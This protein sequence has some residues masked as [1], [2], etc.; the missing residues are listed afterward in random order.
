MYKRILVPT[1]GSPI[2]LAATD[3]ALYLARACG[4]EIVALS[5]ACPEALL[6]GVE[7]GLVSAAGRQ[8]EALLE[9]ADL[10]VA[11][12][13]GRARSQGV[14]CTTDTAYSLTPAEAIVDAAR[15]HQCDLI[16]MGSHG[17]R[18]LSDRL[19]G[20]VTQH[21]LRYSAVP[22]MVLRPPL[23]DAVDNARF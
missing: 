11:D 15:A 2:S 14:P 18:G 5:V 13:A 16:V 6:G 17:Q 3:A 1:D 22:V 19:A 4:S 8:A 9:Q 23:E 10:L 7:R 21:V 12:V 20:S